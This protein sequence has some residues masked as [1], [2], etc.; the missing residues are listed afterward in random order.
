MPKPKVKHVW[1]A[2]IDGSGTH[3][4]VPARFFQELVFAGYKEDPVRIMEMNMTGKREDGTDLIVHN[5]LVVLPRVTPLPT[6]EF[7]HA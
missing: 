7:D 2:T 1:R 6:M 3:F 4:P 5:Y